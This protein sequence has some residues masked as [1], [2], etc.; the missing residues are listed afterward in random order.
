MVCRQIFYLVIIM[1]IAYRSLKEVR[2]GSILVLINTRRKYS[3]TLWEPE[4]NIFYEE[5]LKIERIT[6]K[7]ILQI[8]EYKTLVKLG[9]FKTQKAF[10]QWLKEFYFEDLL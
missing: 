9:T 10:M 3:F 2:S 5:G 1:Y 7:I 4:C 6:T 8:Y